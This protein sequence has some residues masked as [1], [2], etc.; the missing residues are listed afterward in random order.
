MGVGDKREGGGR[1]WE[2]GR[3]GKFWW[4][5]KTKKN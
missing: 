1:N 2:E 4:D 3:K 5:V